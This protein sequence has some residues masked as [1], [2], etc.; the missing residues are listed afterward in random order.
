MDEARQQAEKDFKSFL[1]G[2]QAP[3]LVGSSLVYVMKFDIRSISRMVLN[4]VMC[5]ESGTFI[6]N[7]IQARKKV[8]DIFFYRIVRTDAIYQFFPQFESNLIELC[9]PQYCDSLT[10]GFFEQPWNDIRPLG[11]LPSQTFFG[12]S[13]RSKAEVKDEK[14]NE[15]IYKNVTHDLLSAENRFIF[16]D[17]KTGDDV[18]EHSA[19]VESIFNDFAGLVQ[20]KQVRKEIII[21]NE[22]DHDAVYEEKK[23]FDLEPYLLQSLD[24]VISFFNDDYLLQSVKMM[25]LLMELARSQDYDL[26]ENANFQMKHDLFSKEKIEE[27]TTSKPNRF[28]VRYILGWFREWRPQPMLDK[29][30][31]EKVRRMRRIILDV[32]ECYGGIIYPILL[33]ELEESDEDTPWYYIRN[34]IYLLGRIVTADREAK[35]KAVELIDKH[36]DP[37]SKRPLIM[38]CIAA[39]MF[40]GTDDAVECL[41]SK[42]SLFE[43]DFDKLS[44]EAANR[45][46]LALISFGTERAVK[47]ALDHAFL[48]WS[49]E[50]SLRFIQTNLSPGVVSL[51]MNIIRREVRKMRFSFSLLGNM[52]KAANLLKAVSATH[53]P[54][55]IAL[56]REIQE[57]LPD[58]NK[59]HVLAASLLPDLASPNPPVLA[60][61][62]WLN[63]L[64]GEKNIPEMVCYIT[65]AGLD[66]TLYVKT[67]EPLQCAFEF[68]QG[69]IRHTGVSSLF[70]DAE[71]AFLWI[72]LLDSRDIS[73]VNFGKYDRTVSNLVEITSQA[74]SEELIREGLLQKGEVRQIMG[75]S[76]LPESRFSQRRVTPYF[77]QFKGADNP[78]ECRKVW[79]A[80]ADNPDISTLQQN[81]RMSKYE[82][83]KILFFMMR[84]NMV[85]VDTDR[86]LEDTVAL[87][88]G[89]AMLDVY[90]QR[91]AKR[92]VIFNSYRAAAEVCE[93]IA[94][95][96]SDEV[97]EFAMGILGMYFRNAYA[98]RRIFMAANLDICAQVIKHVLSHVRSPSDD[99]RKEL[100]NY[101]RFTFQEEDTTLLPASPELEQ[102]ILQKIENIEVSNDAFDAGMDQLFNE[103]G[104]N[105]LL[106]AFD[107]A[108]DN[109]SKGAPVAIGLQKDTVLKASE[110]KMLMD[111]YD[112]IAAAYVKPL[113]DFIREIRLNRKIKK[114]TSLEWLDVVDPS[115][116]LLQ[117]SA[118]KMGAQT[119]FHTLTEFRRI[120]HEQKKLKGQAYFSD[121]AIQSILSCYEPLT[122][123][124]PKTFSLDLSDADLDSKKEVLITRFILRQV[125]ELTENKLN[126]II[127]AGLSTFDKFMQSSPEEIA[128]VTGLTHQLSEDVF[129]KFY[130]YRQIYYISKDDEYREKFFRMFEAKLNV[131]REIHAEIEKIAASDESET[132][133]GRK[134]RESLKQD[135]QQ[136]L[137]SLFILLCI[138]EEYDLIESIQQE[139]YESRIQRLEEYLNK[140]ASK[141]VA[142]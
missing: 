104:M 36:L 52:E 50:F 30:L 74:E 78:Q 35:G 41:V 28:L 89:F 121:T 128:A 83:Y 37:A 46:A 110:E 91:I 141:I 40:I 92:P 34:L 133:E 42:L 130:Q 9:P 80:L 106:G 136:I 132:E 61:N 135:R 126:R 86:K 56:C 142:A 79:D 71:N 90:L 4:W 73:Q 18:A 100:L 7:I 69:K 44:I 6:D 77:L 129:M 39:L 96:A 117:R 113:K 31:V 60:A 75:T 62:R 20:D 85:S 120:L 70:M 8:F 45:I 123:I 26:E 68:Q 5:Q 55:I 139:V 66:G 105:D 43:K 63:Q 25:D 111:L 127:L 64:A 93:G 22:A 138:Q 84:H 95:T 32:L 53:S 124:L 97:V 38:Q 76:I 137:Q 58:H 88:D 102:T 134:W 98:R 122:G 23:Q 116:H 118:E 48:N 59:L 19:K 21:A 12:V 115:I 65:E 131:L 2:N 140:L 24:L 67:T 112:N 114:G 51:A 1:S 33:S 108:I 54:E 57:T 27:Y 72:F 81:L 16:A 49:K 11:D 3:A 87:E 82:L 14:F 125:P 119:V 13:K 101:I 109:L 99:S 15:S 17:E 94:Q 107:A 103:E 47:P 10:V 29:L